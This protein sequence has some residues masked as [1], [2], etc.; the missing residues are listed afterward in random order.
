MK[1]NTVLTILLFWSLLFQVSC[2]KDGGGEPTPPPPPPEEE[3]LKIS[4][5]ASSLNIT[6]GAQFDFTVTV[7]S[8]MPANGVK[9]EYTVRG[10]SD[11]QVYPQG[12]AIETKTASTA[13]SLSGLPRQKFC[14]T[15]I[16]VTSLSKSSNTA[17]TSFRVVYK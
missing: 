4:T 14:V 13:I 2:S 8:K 3:A 16:T 15:S 11:N 7:D 10:E 5:N 9:I 17:S 6:A 12:P 1:K